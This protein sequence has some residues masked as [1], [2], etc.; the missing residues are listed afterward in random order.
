MEETKRI[1]TILVADDD[2]DL[3]NM[4]QAMLQM[5]RYNVITAIDGLDALKQIESHQVDL[6][7]LDIMMPSL[8]GFSVLKHLRSGPLASRMPV[9][10]LSALNDSVDFPAEVT[11]EANLYLTKPFSQLELTHAVMTLLK[12]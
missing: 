12:D 5:A 2:P 1:K 9:I 6:V 7:V 8:D 10:M 3:R 4:V 11:E